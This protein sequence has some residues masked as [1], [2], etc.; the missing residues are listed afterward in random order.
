[1]LFIR[2][3]SRK[4]SEN[5]NKTLGKHRCGTKALAV[6]VDEEVRIFSFSQI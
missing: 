2:K 4:N 6:R 5:R 1:M 3:K